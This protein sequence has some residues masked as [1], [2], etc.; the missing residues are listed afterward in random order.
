MTTRKKKANRKRKL[1]GTSIPVNLAR[2]LKISRFIEHRR[3][4]IHVSNHTRAY[5]SS[6]YFLLIS[7]TVR[8]IR[9]R[10]ARTASICIRAI[11]VL[12]F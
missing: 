5:F 3:K 11:T 10:E 6:R 7:S 1:A 2:K 12:P 9:R 4:N 8:N